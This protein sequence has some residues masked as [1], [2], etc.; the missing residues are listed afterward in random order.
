M[1][2]KNI[3]Y[4]K[5]IEPYLYMKPLVIPSSLFLG[6]LLL[7][8]LGRINEGWVVLILFVVCWFITGEFR[9]CREVKT[10]RMLSIG[11]YLVIGGFCV[12]GV[13]LELA[14]LII[15]SFLPILPWAYY[16]SLIYRDKFLSSDE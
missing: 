15:I 11:Y 9:I 10:Y 1:N 16:S 3:E 5:K 4:K 2:K 14:L 13:Y 8:L 12:L 6:S 7:F